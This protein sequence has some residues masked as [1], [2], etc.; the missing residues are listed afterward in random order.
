MNGATRMHEA[1][2]CYLA[3]HEQGDFCDMK[4]HRDTPSP[5]PRQAQQ[6]F[7]RPRCNLCGQS[8]TGRRIDGAKASDAYASSPVRDRC[9]NISSMT[10][11]KRPC[12][13]LANFTEDGHVAVLVF[14]AQAREGISDEA[15]FALAMSAC[16]E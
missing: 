1:E 12:M 16:E 5:A 2:K 4:R 7:F 6:T 14:V 10:A 13:L 11:S 3:S 15:R 8:R 9:E